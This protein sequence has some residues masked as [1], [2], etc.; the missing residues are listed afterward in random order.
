MAAVN[1][2]VTGGAGGSAAGGLTCVRLAE[3]APDEHLL[4]SLL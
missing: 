3:V 4:Y 2:P 1:G